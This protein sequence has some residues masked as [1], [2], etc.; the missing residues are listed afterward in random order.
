[1]KERSHEKGSLAYCDNFNLSLASKYI[2]ERW[3]LEKHRL[4]HLGQ[5][6]P[7]TSFQ[8]PAALEI[9][10]LGAGGWDPLLQQ[11]SFYKQFMQR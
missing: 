6:P 4:A 8:P 11:S 10:Q 2:Y 7:S 5:P 9:P 3:E 1:M